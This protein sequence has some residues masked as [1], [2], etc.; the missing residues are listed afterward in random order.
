MF[1]FDEPQRLQHAGVDFVRDLAGFLDQAIGDV[2]FDVQR[3]EQGA[4]L[5]DHADVAAKLEQLLLSHAAHFFAQH[6][7]A[8]GIR[9]EQAKRQFQ[10]QRLAGA[11]HAHQDFGFSPTQV[12]EI[13][14][15]TGWSKAMATSSKRMAMA[16]SF[17]REWLCARR[18]E[19]R[20][21]GIV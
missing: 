5:E 10:N 8:A 6:D 20:W 17:D 2:L 21:L 4:L 13:P 7:D 15:S 12:N 1:Q 3:V 19:E 18:L 16:G 11:R 14:S 9:L